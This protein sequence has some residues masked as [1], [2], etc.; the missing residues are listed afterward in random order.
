MIALVLRVEI[1][2][3]INW[4]TLKMYPKGKN[5]QTHDFMILDKWFYLLS[6]PGSLIFKMR[7]AVPALWIC[8]EDQGLY[9]EV[10]RHSWH[11]VGT[12]STQLSL[13]WKGSKKLLGCNTSLQCYKMWME[14]NCACSYLLA[15]SQ[16]SFSCCFFAYA[17]AVEEGTPQHQPPHCAEQSTASV[18]LSMTQNSNQCPISFTRLINIFFICCVTRWGRLQQIIS[19]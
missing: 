9:S 19:V 1:S 4:Y 11:L 10:P 13:L 6:R 18:T 17:A 7:R 5:K 15:H 2:T 14:H 12:H 8:F 3:D 16:E